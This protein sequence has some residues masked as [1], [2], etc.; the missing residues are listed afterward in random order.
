MSNISQTKKIVQNSDRSFVI[1]QE[2]ND[3]EHNVY[4]IL[5]DSQIFRPNWS[6]SG[7]QYKIH[8]NTIRHLLKVL[9]TDISI[10]IIK[11][12]LFW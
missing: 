9:I 1:E 5:C 10:F 4:T 11:L 12:I 6:S 8:K 3:A 2:I 7:Q